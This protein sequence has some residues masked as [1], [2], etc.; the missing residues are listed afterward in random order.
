[1][2]KIVNSHELKIKNAEKEFVATTKESM[3]KYDPNDRTKRFGFKQWDF[4]AGHT[5][6]AR[7][8]RE[9]F[10]KFVI[11]GLPDNMTESIDDTSSDSNLLYI[12][13]DKQIDGGLPQM[14]STY[15]PDLY[16]Q[17]EQTLS[18]EQLLGLII[19]DLKLFGFE[20][21]DNKTNEK[22]DEELFDFPRIN[23]DIVKSLIDGKEVIVKEP[24]T[25]PDRPQY[26]KF[27]LKEEKKQ[28]EQHISVGNNNPIC[29]IYTNTTQQP[30]KSKVQDCKV[31]M[32]VKIS[33]L[34]LPKPVYERFVQLT[35]NKYDPESDIFKLTNSATK[36]KKINKK[37]ILEL[38]K[39]ILNEAWT[40]DLNY[41]PVE[42]LPPHILV[43]D[44]IL[45]EQQN[46]KEMED[47]SFNQNNMQWTIFKIF[48]ITEKK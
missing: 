31:S 46:K 24:E 13:I 47:Y 37:K 12:A 33:K 17:W 29:F 1:L 4:L 20:V 8:Q 41:V 28:K 35:G 7:K 38:F 39:N 34:N 45:Q 32:K 15:E 2:A 19:R 40:A 6:E 26:L 21:K 11:E 18:K 14:P 48:N 10:S 36:E 16:W 23:P 42:N 9:E 44:Q 30:M 25:V 27:P 3:N 43:E 5:E 22:K